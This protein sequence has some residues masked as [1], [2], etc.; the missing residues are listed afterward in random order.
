MLF[1][2]RGHGVRGVQ[3]LFNGSR[4]RIGGL[5][6]LAGVGQPLAGGIELWLKLLVLLNRL[7]PFGG[8]FGKT[9]SSLADPS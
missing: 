5:D 1:F 2:G 8:S 7:V 6:L 3:L 9:L 4:F